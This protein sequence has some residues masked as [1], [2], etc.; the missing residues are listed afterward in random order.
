MEDGKDHINIY[1]KGETELGRLLSNFSH[2]P[3]NTKDGLFLSLEG[4][5]YWLLFKDDEFKKL[6]GFKAKEYARSKNVID[7]PITDQLIEFQENFKLA[8][9]NK[10]DQHH[11]IK[12]MLKNSDLPLKHYYNYSGKIVYVKNGQWVVDYWEQL[13]KEIKNG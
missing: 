12:E 6:I 10:I 7:W 9:K 4:Y 2:T 8:M 13:R 1:S 11:N 5:W 3:T